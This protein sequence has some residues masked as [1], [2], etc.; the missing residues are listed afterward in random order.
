MILIVYFLP[1]GIV[2]AVRSGGSARGARTGGEPS[3]TAEAGR[4]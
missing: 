3:P 4:E 1:Q 2:P